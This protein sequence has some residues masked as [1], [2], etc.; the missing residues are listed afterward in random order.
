MY[1]VVLSLHVLVCVCLIGLVLLQRSEGGALG[2]GGGGSSALMSGRGAADALARMTQFAGGLFLITSLSLTVISGAA[3]SS[4]NRSI[5]DSLP[6]Q[7]GFRQTPS[8]PATPA[9]ATPAP[10][11]PAPA[12]PDPTQSSLPQN[13]LASIMPGP[14]S[15]QASTIPASTTAE[16]AA[17]IG[18]QHQTVTPPPARA[19]TQPVSTNPVRVATQAVTT[20]SHTAPAPARTQSGGATTQQASGAQPNLVLPQTAGSLALTQ[21]AAQTPESSDPNA[22]TAVRRERAAGPDQ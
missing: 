5:F 7:T 12:H 19:T 15:A 20:P 10:A 1:L 4:A 2:M 17:P 3:S 21:A 18:T 6:A 16:H 13:T 14:S 11:Q 8:A 22:V 9:P